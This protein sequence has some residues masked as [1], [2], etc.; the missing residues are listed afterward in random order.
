VKN[1]INKWYAV[2]SLYKKEVVG[3]PKGKDKYYDNS[4]NIY[5]ERVV[6]FNAKSFDSA[7]RLAK[8]EAREYVKDSSHLN[9]YGQKVKTTIIN[10][11]DCYWLLDPPPRHGSEVYSSTF[12]M[13]KSKKINSVID[14]KLG[15][16][17]TKV[18]VKKRKIFLNKAFSGR[19]Y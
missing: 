13:S 1:N 3:K 19:V 14:E 15:V 4:K 9:P 12:L 5:E 10:A 8:K 11:T 17:E 16:Y 6:I 2:K 7:I 18:D